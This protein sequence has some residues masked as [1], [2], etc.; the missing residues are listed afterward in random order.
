MFT[1]R[2]EHFNCFSFQSR[3]SDPYLMRFL[4]GLGHFM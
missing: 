2:T 4:S 3:D 1:F